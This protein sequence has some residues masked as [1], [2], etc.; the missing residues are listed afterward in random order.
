MTSRTCIIAAAAA[1]TLAATAAN[2]GVT[3]YSN[4][5]SWT[6]AG[7]AVI[8]ASGP[9]YFFGSDITGD[10]T[11]LA[12]SASTTSATAGTIDGGGF[13][14]GGA[15]YAA[16]GTGTVSGSGSSFTFSAGANTSTLVIT[17]NA[18]IWGF[19]LQY[20]TTAGAGELF[21]QGSNNAPP[22][23]QSEITIGTWMGVVNTAATINQIVISL[24]GGDTLTI[25]GAQYL[26][27]P[28]PGAAA[29]AGLAGVVCVSRRRRA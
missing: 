23:G 5:G 3:T 20:T 10:P 25:T 7:Q 8:S 13:Y 24:N 19:A 9:G 26:A 28:A 17:V 12:F 18:N 11:P 1:T 2:A 14:Y 6:S 21:M 22:L 29:L 15:S 27:I 16:T 4:I